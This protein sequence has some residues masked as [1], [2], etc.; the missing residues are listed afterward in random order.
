MG[1]FSTLA[2][3]LQDADPDGIPMPLLLPGSTDGRIF[4]N[5]G[6]QTY[7]FTPMKLPIG[8]NFFATI[9]GADERIP[10]EAMDFGANAIYELIRRYKG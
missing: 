9:H 8:F 1:L 2:G 3:V 4:A 6:I 10:V 7:G 5:L